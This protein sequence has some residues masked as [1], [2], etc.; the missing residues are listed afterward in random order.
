MTQE[1]RT[2]LRWSAAGLA[3]LAIR[4]PT[5]E[6]P[7]SPAAEDAW[8]DAIAG[9]KYRAFIDVGR[10][11]T[12]GTPFRRA[13]A[14]LTAMHDQYG[15]TD[16]DVGFAFGAYS[17]ALAYLLSQRTWDQ[18][19]IADL[20]APQL[21]PGDAAALRANPGAAITIGADGV[22]QLRARGG[23]VLACRNTITRWSRELSTKRGET[24]DVVAQALTGGLHEGVEP[25][26]A[27]IAA[28]VIAQS[29]SVAYVAIM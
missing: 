20:I 10:F 13:T 27:M 2:F 25:V 5:L 8:L 16:A 22:R 11:A 4:R 26:P 3:G 1:R 21:N 19:G 24:V 18:L 23:R 6:A 12:D 17:T 28:A 15:A 7:V 9:K 14:L 29:R